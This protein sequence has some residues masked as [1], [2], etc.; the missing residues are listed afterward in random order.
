MG[1]YNSAVK[2]YYLNYLVGF[3]ISFFTFGI[4]TYFFPPPGKGEDGKYINE[5]FDEFSSVLD[6]VG[7]PAD[8]ESLGVEVLSKEALADKRVLPDMLNP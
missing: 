7:T 8:S 6:G 3:G 2:I 1:R 4:I 5:P